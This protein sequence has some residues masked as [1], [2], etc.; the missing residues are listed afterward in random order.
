MKRISILLIGIFTAIAGMTIASIIGNTNT[1]L[2]CGF[3]LIA[4]LILDIQLALLQEKI[5]EIKREIK[6]VQS[7]MNQM[8]KEVRS[9]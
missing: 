1:V 9:N 2:V 4:L 5:T 6:E 3:S 8:I 7:Q